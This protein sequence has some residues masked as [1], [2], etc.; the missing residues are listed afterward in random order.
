MLRN[1]DF[2]RVEKI[3]KHLT[4]KKFHLLYEPRSFNNPVGSTQMDF[5][6]IRANYG[7]SI[8]VRAVPILLQN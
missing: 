4:K 7:H 8:P 1:V 6:W 3:V 2:L 5:W